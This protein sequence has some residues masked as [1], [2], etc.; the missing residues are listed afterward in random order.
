MSLSGSQN[1]LLSA[2][3][4]LDNSITNSHRLCHAT[5]FNVIIL[6]VY[7]Y[8]NIVHFYCY[9]PPHW[10][11]FVLHCMSFVLQQI[12]NFSVDLRWKWWKD[13]FDN[14]PLI[15]SNIDSSDVISVQCVL[16]YMTF[17]FKS[18]QQR[19]F[20]PFFSSGMSN[21]TEDSSL[22]KNLKGIIVEA[23][24]CRMPSWMYKQKEDIFQIYSESRT[25]SIKLLLDLLHLSTL[26]MDTS[27]SGSPWQDKA[28]FLFCSFA[29]FG[30]PVWSP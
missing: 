17:V 23:E 11:M 18:A 19:A 28:A 13:I 25:F 5:S 2:I 7:I 6:C 9:C 1:I 4:T 3:S 26:Q 24:I 20:E 16:T 21:N 22:W 14:R 27:T 8:D 12:D 15:T 10:L 29:H 30:C